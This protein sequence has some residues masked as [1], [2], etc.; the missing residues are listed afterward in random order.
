VSVHCNSSTASTATG[1]ETYYLKIILNLKK[2]LPT[3]K[4]N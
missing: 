3:F 1:S 2:W 4:M